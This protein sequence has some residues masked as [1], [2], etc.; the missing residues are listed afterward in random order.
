[1]IILLFFYYFWA[2]IKRCPYS[3]RFE[4]SLLVNHDA[5]TQVSQL[6]VPILCDQDIQ[7][8][9]VSMY[10]VMRMTMEKCET[11]LPGHLPNLFLR[12]VLSFT[13]LLIN[14]S[15]HIAHLCI[16]HRYVETCALPTPILLGV[17]E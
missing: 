12:K 16:L 17:D 15:L 6:E 13:F 2:K 8:F 3:F 11:E 9:D 10:D 7:R 1:M 4:I 14:Q 5:F